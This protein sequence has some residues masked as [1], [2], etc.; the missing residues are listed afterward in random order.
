[1]PMMS[2][3]DTDTSS[4]YKMV[5]SSIPM[6]ENHTISIGSIVSIIVT[7]ENANAV[8]GLRGV[9]K[10]FLLNHAFMLPMNLGAFI[11][12]FLQFLKCSLDGSNLLKRVLLLL[13]LQC[14]DFRL[15]VLYEALVAKLRHYAAQEALLV[16]KV[17]LQ[18]LYLLVLID[19]LIQRHKVLVRSDDKRRTGSCRLLPVACCLL[20]VACFLSPVACRLFR[21][22]LHHQIAISLRYRNNGYALI[23][24]IHYHIIILLANNIDS[25]DIDNI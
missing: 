12:L 17:C 4:L 8:R 19:E 2:M 6:M 13:A 5:A 7:K 3:L 15:C 21:K 16:S 18:F 24:K 25:L 11:L 1:M 14:N 20:P 10:T 9:T 23:R 22:I